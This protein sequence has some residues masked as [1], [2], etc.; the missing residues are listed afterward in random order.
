MGPL[1]ASSEHLE[2]SLPKT[3]RE[4]NFLGAIPAAPF[5]LFATGFL[6]PFLLA[7]PE[8]GSWLCPR[9]PSAP[10]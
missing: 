9:D 5:P 7:G 3:C 2:R 10:G 8:Q 1:P 6:Q 4:T